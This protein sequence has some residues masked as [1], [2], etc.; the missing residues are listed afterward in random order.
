MADEDLDEW[1]G[2][3]LALLVAVGE[4]SGVGR[5]EGLASIPCDSR[6]CTS[7]RDGPLLLGRSRSVSGGGC[8]EPCEDK[9][10]WF[11]C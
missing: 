5:G 6:G 11:R 1:V 2:E 9:A 4:E 3:G 8:E 10:G 7:F